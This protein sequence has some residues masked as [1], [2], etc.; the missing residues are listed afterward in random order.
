MTDKSVVRS[1]AVFF[2]VAM[3]VPAAALAQGTIT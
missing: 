1:A 2:F 3:L